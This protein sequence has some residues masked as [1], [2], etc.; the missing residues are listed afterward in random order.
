VLNDSDALNLPL[1]KELSKQ[2]K[3][4]MKHAVDEIGR[5][6]I[7]EGQFLEAEEEDG[8][9]FEDAVE[10]PA[11]K[12][13]LPT[14]VASSGFGSPRRSAHIPATIEPAQEGVS[15]SQITKN[16]LP[17]RRKWSKQQTDDLRLAC[18]KYPNQWETMRRVFPSL[19]E[20]SGVQLKDKHRATFGSRKST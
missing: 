20:F 3:R 5:I 2:L 16:L 10:E 6:H 4:F 14:I 7:S 18:D 1:K 15:I 17:K 13:F 12:R 9:D 11:P 19:S 8:D